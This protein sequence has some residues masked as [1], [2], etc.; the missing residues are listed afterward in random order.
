MAFT[1]RITGRFPVEE[2]K[3][4]ARGGH[5]HGEAPLVRIEVR[6]R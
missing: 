1:A 5:A 6:P 4:D 2:H 3:L